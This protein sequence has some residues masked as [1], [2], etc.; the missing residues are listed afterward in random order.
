MSEGTDEIGQEKGPEAERTVTITGKPILIAG[1]I[2]FLSLRWLR[3][4]K[5]RRGTPE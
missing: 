5:S 3:R 4:R 2:A 1:V